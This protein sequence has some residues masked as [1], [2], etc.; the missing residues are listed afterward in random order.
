MNHPTRGSLDMGQ[1]AEATVGSGA[2]VRLTGGQRQAWNG[3]A[4]EATGN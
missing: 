2:A 3:R 4:A 1:V